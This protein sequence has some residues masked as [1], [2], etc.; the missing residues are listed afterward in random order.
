M[1]K[2][3]KE[4]KKLLNKWE[5]KYQKAL[6][7]GTR[8]VDEIK[9]TEDK[10]GWLFAKYNVDA[11]VHIDDELLYLIGGNYWVDKKKK[12]LEYLRK[13]MIKYYTKKSIKEYENDN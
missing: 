10:I 6:K 5:E 2:F 12:K 8:S 7:E 11:I 9:N 3:N 4:G 1:L 13:E